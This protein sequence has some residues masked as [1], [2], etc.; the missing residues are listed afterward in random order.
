MSARVV[1]IYC[2]KMY[3]NWQSQNILLVYQHICMTI[4]VYIPKLNNFLKRPVRFCYFVKIDESCVC[5]VALPHDTMALSAVC[6]CG[7]S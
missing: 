3:K 6:D 5:F 2:L 1:F 7:I 4:H